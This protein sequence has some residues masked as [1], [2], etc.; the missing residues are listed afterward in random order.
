MLTL[1]DL[2]SRRHEYKIAMLC[3][4][5]LCS[6]APS[7]RLAVCNAF[8]AERLHTAMYPPFLRF[9]QDEA[10]CIPQSTASLSRHSIPRHIVIGTSRAAPRT[11]R[12][13]A[14]LYL[15][16]DDF[17]SIVLGLMFDLITTTQP[18]MT[19]PISIALVSG[20]TIVSW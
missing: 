19:V 2:H 9:E 5:M 16:T 6:P 12:S 14:Q 17:W 4:H 10:I 3:S 1:C 18:S 15:T 8:R 20:H 7:R 13:K 11:S